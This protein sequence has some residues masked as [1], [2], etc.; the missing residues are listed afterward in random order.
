MPD[1]IDLKKQLRQQMRIARK[2]LN[3]EQRSIAGRSLLTHLQ[4]IDQFN[5][6]NSI[7]LYLTSDG[8]IDPIHVIEY[9][10]ALGKQVFLPVLD[11]DKHNQLLFI[12]YLKDTP[13]CLNKYKISE[14]AA[15]YQNTLDANQLDLVLLPLVAFDDSGSRMGMGGGYYDRSFAFKTQ[16]L[17]ATP[18]LIGLAHQLQKVDQLAVESWDIPLAAIVTDKQI[19]IA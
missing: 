2:S 9:C 14:P 5:D 6:A 19:Y 7:A 17:A 1:I 8:E 12:N 11:P 4:S 13:M 15:P 3:A 16:T 10:W 18:H